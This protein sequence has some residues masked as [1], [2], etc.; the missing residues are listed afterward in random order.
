MGLGE[1][2]RH[3]QQPKPLREI[4]PAELIDEAQGAG[5][6]SPTAEVVV[7]ISA[8]RTEFASMRH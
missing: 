3:C 4:P 2:G 7:K 6:P 8:K 5:S 1:M